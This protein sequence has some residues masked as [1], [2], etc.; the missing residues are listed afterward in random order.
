MDCPLNSAHNYEGIVDVHGT[1]DA[2]HVNGG[3]YNTI[4]PDNVI[5]PNTKQ[6]NKMTGCYWLLSVDKKK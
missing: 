6:P 3:D 1:N 4:T 2:V 5:T